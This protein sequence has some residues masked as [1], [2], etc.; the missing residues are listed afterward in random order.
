MMCKSGPPTLAL[1]SEFSK[2]SDNTC[3]KEVLNA[4]S[5]LLKP[6]VWDKVG[7]FFDDSWS[8]ENHEVFSFLNNTCFSNPKGL[9]LVTLKISSPVSFSR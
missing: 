5:N 6:K 4:Y 7:T 9:P 1:I 2:Y 8:V 3:L